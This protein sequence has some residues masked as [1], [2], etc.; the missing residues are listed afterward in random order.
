MAAGRTYLDYNATAPL[1]ASALSACLSALSA[2]GNPSSVHQEGRAA[3]ALV[4]AAR[5]KVGQLVGVSAERVVFVSGGTEGANL[6]LTPGLKRERAPGGATRLVTVATEH[7]A[8]LQGHRFEAEAVEVLP[9]EAAGVL[10]LDRLRTAVDPGNGGPALVALQSANSETGVIQDIRAAAEIVHDAGGLLVC[11]A[12]QAIGR[13][14]FNFA[15]VGAD[16]VILSGH[17]LGGPKGTGAVILGEGVR[18]D[19]PLIRGGGQERGARS[20]TENVVGLASFGAAAEDAAGTDDT[21]RLARLRD[22]FETQLRVFRD[23]CVIFGEAAV[24]LPNT[25][26]FA[27][28]GCRAETLLMA[29]DLEG[30]A[31]SSGSACSSGKVGRSHVLQ[32]MGA[33]PELAAG[34]LR[35]SVG[36]GSTAADIDR[37]MEVLATV[38]QRMQKRSLPRA[39]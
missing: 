30:V 29:F 31:V 37:F 10:D 19:G 14:P 16:A 13:V 1:R 39:A 17:K 27:V 28:P 32:A 6:L 2:Y 38:M 35:V 12:V 34:A 21:T 11:D 22:A 5:I 33:D 25:S 36:W 20:G 26:C 8:V 23:D 7:A 4:E 9:V 15:E 18:L 3:R 24:R